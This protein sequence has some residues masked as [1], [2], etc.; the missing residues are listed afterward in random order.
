[1]AE[2]VQTGEYF[3]INA[4]YT[5]TMVYYV[6]KLLSEAYVLQ[7]DTTCNRQISTDGELVFKAQ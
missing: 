4:T 5:T 3:A 7:N 1:M 6:I 2:L